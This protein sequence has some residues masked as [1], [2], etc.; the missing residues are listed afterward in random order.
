MGGSSGSVPN[1]EQNGV[2]D[3]SVEKAMKER[4]LESYLL[5]TMCSTHQFGDTPK[6][7]PTTA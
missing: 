4:C 2:I 6:D 5:L 3:E 7:H 1:A